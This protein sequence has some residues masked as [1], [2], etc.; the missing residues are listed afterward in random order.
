MFLKQ[1][2]IE[3]LFQE[4][5]KSF[6]IIE[7]LP[8][9]EGNLVQLVQKFNNFGFEA[10]ALKTKT[11]GGIF[12]SFQS[13]KVKGNCESSPYTFKNIFKGNLMLIYPNPSKINDLKVLETMKTSTF[14]ETI[15]V[16]DI[17]VLGVYHKGL[18]YHS[19]TFFK[20]ITTHKNVNIIGTLNN[21]VQNTI[22]FLQNPT[23]TIIRLLM[24][25]TASQNQNKI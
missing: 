14:L 23:I 4:N 13:Q 1:Y 21:N 3:K 9:K 25:S 15:K 12:S 17:I 6:I 2:K 18:F 20:T 22:T 5:P 8:I 7:L 19:N 16:K 10:K 11:A 24:L